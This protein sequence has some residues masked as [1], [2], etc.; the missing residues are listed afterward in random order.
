MKQM[1]KDAQRILDDCRENHLHP[2]NN[3][4]HPLHRQALKAIAELEEKVIALT[5]KN[6]PLQKSKK[7]KLKKAK[8]M[9]REDDPEFL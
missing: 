8:L 1:L 7:M 2:A 5:D 4:R 3:R 9:L 6:R